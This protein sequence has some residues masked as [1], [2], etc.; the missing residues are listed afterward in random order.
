MLIKFSA[1]VGV[2]SVL[3]L[4][5]AKGV[6]GGSIEGSVLGVVAFAFAIAAGVAT[7]FFVHK[8]LQFGS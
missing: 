5:A 3:G 2:V 6:I 8:V 7:G 1:P 4:L